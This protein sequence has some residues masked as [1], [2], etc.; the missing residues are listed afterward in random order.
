MKAL[1]GAALLG[2]LLPSPVAARRA[3]PPQGASALDAW[4]AYR[5][6]EDRTY[7]LAEDGVHRFSCRVGGPFV[8]N[9]SHPGGPLA[10]TSARVLLGWR[11]G[12]V[13]VSLDGAEA[14]PELVDSIANLVEP[15]R[16]LIL[17]YRPSRGL[18]AH[19]F[20]F[21]AADP[22]LQPGES[23][24]EATAR[25]TG[26]PIARLVAAVGDDGLVHGE[27]IRRA[28]GSVAQYRYRLS[29]LRGRQ[30]MTGCEGF[31]GGRHV[32]VDIEWDAVA[33]D[34]PLPTRVEVSR[35][36]PGS[37]ERDSA[38]FTLSEHAV[39]G[40]VADGLLPKAAP[41]EPPATR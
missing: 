4:A 18:T 21:I 9:L 11:D 38:L 31:V 1:A 28:D 24:I 34:R 10:G 23:G 39:N 19:V 2:L 6:A 29:P 13:R 33:D 15:L 16:E 26:A 35:D 37:D 12:S 7:R 30:V 40:D 41:V 14:P 25:D 17:P 32:T 8:Q 3:A 20:R 5:D 27:W 22:F 36:A